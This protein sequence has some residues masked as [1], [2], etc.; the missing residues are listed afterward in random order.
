MN[1]NQFIKSVGIGAML[2]PTVPFFAI[3]K[4][5]FQ[6]D[7]QLDKAL[8]QKFV[9]ASHSKMDVVKE[10][11]AEHPNLINAAHD[12]KFGDFET[13]LGAA[14]HVGYKELALYF[15]ENGA[16]ANIFTA[17]LFG[18][19][20][21]LKPMLEFSP[22]LLHARGPHGFTLLHHAE[23]GGDEALEVKDFLMSKGLK[24]TKVALY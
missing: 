23:K 4:N 17:A 19:M 11:H 1:R 10:L 3:P 8:V 16:Q 14:S 7:P 24:E 22:A 5:E 15:L 6:E 12:W 18:K 2:I 20:D 21:I 9:G 13:G